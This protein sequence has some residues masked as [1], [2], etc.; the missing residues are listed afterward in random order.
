MIPHISRRKF[1]R[2]A[3]VAMG[4]GS[5][6]RLFPFTP[7]TAAEAAVTPDL[8]QWRPEILPLVQ[9]IATTPREQ[10]VAMLAA[11]LRK[12]VPFRELM[13]ATF[14][15][16]LQHDGHHTVY[17]VHAALEL[18]RQLPPAE[19]ALPLFWAVDVVK[20]HIARF[21]E[22]PVPPLAGPLPGNGGA[23]FDAAMEA[24]DQERAERAVIALARSHGTGAALQ[25]LCRYGARDWS[26]IGHVPIGLSN[27]WR[28]LEVIG[29]QHAEPTLRYLVREVHVRNANRTE[30]Q[31]YGFN[32]ELVEQQFPKLPPDWPD[33]RADEKATLEL[34]AVIRSGDW[35]AASQWTAREL[36]AGR[37]QAGTVWDAVHLA[38]G[39]FMIRFKLGNVR[40]GN[41]ALHS[42][43]SG[44]ALHHL[45][46]V[47]EDARTRFLITLQA[48]AWAAAFTKNEADRGMLRE[49]TLTE[50]PV[51]DLPSASNETL[52]KIFALLPPRHAQQEVEDRSGQDQASRLALALGQQP[53]LAEE[54][55]TNARRLVLAKATINSHDVKFPIAIFENRSWVSPRWRPHLLAA[56]VHFLHGTQMPD[57]EV[58]QR[59]RDLVKA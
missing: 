16:A 39:E 51:G 11:Q 21:K 27:A 58:T 3:G 25:R 28:T 44:N 37:V 32:L 49:L 46:K 53:G 15:H 30:G 10:C 40:L 31:S 19:R 47:C 24:W 4:I 48:A 6:G 1:V 12:G 38:A 35:K 54:F 8:M 20:E 5:L 50:M 2:M 14:L 23:E 7:L 33:T 22:T 55:M 18:S 17:L 43:T 42:N 52:E 56:S 9:L 13:A 26:F 45:F 57:N 59:A 34:L 29:E 36:S 41:R